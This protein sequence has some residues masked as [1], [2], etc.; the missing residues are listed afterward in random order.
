MNKEEKEARLRGAIK[1][2]GK[3]TGLWA[4]PDFQ[5]WRNDI[6]KGR[7]KRLEKAILNTDVTVEEKQRLAIS[8][9]LKYQALKS[10]TDDL[11]K[12]NQF[13]EKEATQKLRKLKK[14]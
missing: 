4:N 7:L 5:D 8:N 10:Q 12:I 11:F 9:I 3:Y 2:T 13:I 14:E 6:V 1:R